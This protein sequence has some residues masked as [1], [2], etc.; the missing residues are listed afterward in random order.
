MRAQRGLFKMSVADLQKLEPGFFSDGGNLYLAVEKNSAGDGFNR[1]WIFR[2]QLPG[3]RQRDMGLGSVDQLGA[4]TSGLSVARELAQNA[5]QCLAR[6]V[7]PIDERKSKIAEKAA[8]LPVPTFESVWRDYLAARDG[9]WMRKVAEHWAMTLSTYCEPIN[10]LR[11][12]LV[13]T[14]HVLKCVTP[15][16]KD[17]HDT[18]RRVQNRIERVLAFATVKRYRTGENPARW[19]DHLDHML[20]DPSKIKK[21]KNHDALDYREMPAFIAELR[22]R[23]V[24]ISNLALEFL[25]LCAS[26]TDEVLKAKWSEVDLDAGVWMIPGERMKQ[27]KPHDVPLT[28]RAV[29]VLKASREIGGGEYL[30]TSDRNGAHLSS[31]SLLAL[32]KRRMGRRDITA[33]GMRAAFKTWAG[34]ETNFPRDVVEMCLAHQVGNEV[35]NAYRRGTMI[36]KRRKVLQAWAEYC[37]KGPITNAKVLPL[38]ANLTR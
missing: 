28:P 1:R 10:K 29:E 8:A 26:R 18:A 4:N 36:E 7:D 14:D 2:Y 22:R 21:N 35:E 16:W 34:E 12:D 23:K 27:R 20:P 32:I 6:G 3:G 11:V 30:F 19:V 17:K 37:G 5:R 31:N 9:S 13:D 33:H 25:I 15:I 24:T 38:K